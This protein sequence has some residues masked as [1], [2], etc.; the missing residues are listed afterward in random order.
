[1][2]DIQLVKSLDTETL[3]G[4]RED[5]KSLF[6]VAL[7]SIAAEIR[8][9]FAKDAE[10]AGELCTKRNLGR[11]AGRQGPKTISIAVTDASQTPETPDYIQLTVDQ[12]MSTGAQAAQRAMNER[13]ILT[14]NLVLPPDFDPTKG[15]EGA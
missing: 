6:K 8:T 2:S 15:P 10:E 7:V 9:V 4:K 5:G 13:Q 3:E 12:L 1:M 11:H 14:P